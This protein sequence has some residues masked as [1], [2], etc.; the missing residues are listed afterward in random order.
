L[1][2]NNSL[3]KLEFGRCNIDDSGAEIISQLLKIKKY[4]EL[5]L[6]N[7]EI[8]NK[9]ITSIFKSIEK[10]ESLRIISLDYNKIFN[11][12]VKNI[13]TSLKKNKT[14]QIISMKEANLVESGYNELLNLLKVN[15]NLIM[16]INSKLKK[17]EGNL[18]H[19]FEINKKIMA[20]PCWDINKHRE[21]PEEFKTKLMTFLVSNHIFLKEKKYLKIPKPLLFSIINRFAIDFLLSSKKKLFAPNNKENRKKRKR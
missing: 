9:G 16:V 4:E 15:H 13:F 18:D 11:D 19:L 7:N 20:N 2:Q 1:F 17:Y 14:L 5:N 6:D 21:F 12:G 10:N 8:G 3:T